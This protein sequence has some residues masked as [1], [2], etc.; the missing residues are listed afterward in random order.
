MS[1]SSIINPIPRMSHD[2][3]LKQRVAAVQDPLEKQFMEQWLRVYLAIKEVEDVYIR[4][5]LKT[6]EAMWNAI[7]PI[8]SYLI[9]LLNY[10][11]ESRNTSSPVPW[12]RWIAAKIK[13]QDDRLKVEGKQP[14][15]KLLLQ[16]A[17]A[18]IKKAK[19]KTKVFQSPEKA[20]QQAQAI[21]DGWREMISTL[22]MALEKETDSDNES[23]VTE[24]KNVN[25]TEDA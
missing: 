2:D 16:F 8:R 11:G 10:T 20:Q 13:V 15:G 12:Y 5:P 1:W 17:D 7:I 6:A 21:R 23:H 19:V 3:H 25:K 18:C 4:S 22:K 14:M 24:L 9:G